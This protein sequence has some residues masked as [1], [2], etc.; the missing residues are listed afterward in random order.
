MQK[1]SGITP[2][3][4]Y[5]VRLCERAFLRPWSYPNL[6]RDQGGGKELCDVLIVFGRDV[7]I[8]SDKSCAYPDTGDDVK[9]WGR[10]FKSSIKESARQVYGAERW[11]GCESR[12]ALIAGASFIEFRQRWR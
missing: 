3:E 1:S 11:I 5:L 6:Y 8:F 10:W 4:K 7:I 2:T 12:M 9:D